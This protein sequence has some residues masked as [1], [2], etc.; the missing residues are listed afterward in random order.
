MDE[1]NLCI[2]SIK[3]KEENVAKHINRTVAPINK[4]YVF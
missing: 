1:N 2:Q 3:K 4:E